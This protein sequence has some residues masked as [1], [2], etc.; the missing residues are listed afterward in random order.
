MPIIIQTGKFCAVVTVYKNN[1]GVF[2]MS[3]YAVITDQYQISSKY[4]LINLIIFL[5]LRLDSNYSNLSS[6]EATIYNHYMEG[7]WEE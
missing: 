6:W 2:N 7:E 5:S 3:I 4:I 1:E